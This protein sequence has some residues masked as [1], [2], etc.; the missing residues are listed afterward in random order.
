MLCQPPD[1]RKVGIWNWPPWL[2]ADDRAEKPKSFAYRLSHLTTSG[3]IYGVVNVI[4]SI[5]EESP[6]MREVKDAVL[7]RQAVSGRVHVG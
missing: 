1:A 5:H 4:V 7:A 6:A 2:P 3:T